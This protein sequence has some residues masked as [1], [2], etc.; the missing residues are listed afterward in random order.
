MEC[1]RY[2]FFSDHSIILS[3]YQSFP[4]AWIANYMVTVGD[5]APPPKS[6]QVLDYAPY[7]PCGRYPGT[8]PISVPSTVR[9]DERAIGQY[10]YIYLPGTSYLTF[11]EASVYGVG[12]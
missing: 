3:F 5:L 7:R 1:F 10:V 4:A 8:P 11:C 2:D 6:P 9:C 12:K